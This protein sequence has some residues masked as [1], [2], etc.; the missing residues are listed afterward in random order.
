MQPGDVKETL[1]DSSLINSWVDNV[2]ETP[3]SKGICE[4]TKWYVDFYK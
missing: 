4:F 3:L 2:S 1:S